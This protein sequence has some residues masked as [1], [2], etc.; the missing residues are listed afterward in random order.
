LANAAQHSEYALLH[1]GIPSKKIP[2]SPVVVLWANCLL[3]Q[4]SDV[5][6]IDD[7]LVAQA[8]GKLEA[9][10]EGHVTFSVFAATKT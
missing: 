8:D 10:P 2:L 5:K 6:F 4:N 7:T 9:D 3:A 1:R